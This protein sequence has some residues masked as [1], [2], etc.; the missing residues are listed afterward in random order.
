[1][2]L[3]NYQMHSLEEIPQGHRINS[4]DSI[5]GNPNPPPHETTKIKFRTDAD[6]YVDNDETPARAKIP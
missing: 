6:K 1:M 4:I 2:Y 3:H 5:N